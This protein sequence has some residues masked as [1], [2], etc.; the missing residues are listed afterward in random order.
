MLRSRLPSRRVNSAVA[1]LLRYGAASL[2]T[3]AVSLGLLA[4]L[5]WTLTPGWA[6]LIAVG[7]GSFISFEL[8]R[9]W[10]W[11]H[12]HRGA[13]WSQMMLFAVGS[14]IFLALSTLAVRRVAEAF[15]PHTAAALRTLAIETTTVLFFGMR[16]GL[17]YVIFDRM[18]FRPSTLP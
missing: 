17:Q 5:L 2:L 9:R 16:W 7:V 10:V 13:V 18:L 11:K 15:G 4:V 3:T 8:N 6:N 14:L 12:E 1:K